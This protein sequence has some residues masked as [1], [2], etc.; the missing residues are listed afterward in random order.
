[1]KVDKPDDGSDSDGNYKFNGEPKQ[2]LSK[3]KNDQNDGVSPLLATV[4]A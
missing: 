4:A 2:D 1:V 3:F